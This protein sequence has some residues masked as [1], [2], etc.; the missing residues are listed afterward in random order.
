M[1]DLVQQYID[2]CIRIGLLTYNKIRKYPLRPGNLAVVIKV[3][4]LHIKQAF[5][6]NNQNISLYGNYNLYLTDIGLE[7][8]INQ[9]KSYTFYFLR[10]TFPHVFANLKN[11][12][13]IETY[14]G[15][16]NF[17][18][19]VGENHKVGTKN[20]AVLVRTFGVNK[21]EYMFDTLVE[22]RKE[23]LSLSRYYPLEQFTLYYLFKNKK[24]V[25]YKQKAPLI[26]ESN[27]RGV[28]VN[29]PHLKGKLW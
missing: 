5:E 10:S 23:V 15:L 19:K 13:D 6:I 9:F 17:K 21:I 29:L 22:A 28:P 7:W 2:Q 20:K 3:Y 16:N 18:G 25:Y 27:R 4:A 24:G 1:E 26:M 12:K 11:I 14:L 8:I